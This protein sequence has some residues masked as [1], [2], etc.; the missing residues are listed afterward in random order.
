M[1]D[2]SLG[3]KEETKEEKYLRNDGQQLSE[4]GDRPKSL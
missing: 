3:R 2:W 1:C 4:H